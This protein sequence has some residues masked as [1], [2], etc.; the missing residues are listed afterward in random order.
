[1]AGE[2]AS[3]C[4]RLASV[5]LV[6]AMAAAPIALPVGTALHDRTEQ[7]GCMDRPVDP[8]P[9]YEEA[10]MLPHEL[11]PPPD[12]PPSVPPIPDP[13]EQISCPPSAPNN[14]CEIVNL[15]VAVAMWF[16]Q[17]FD[18]NAEQHI[19][20]EGDCA[21]LKQAVEELVGDLVGQVP[22]DAGPTSTSVGA[23]LHK[24]SEFHLTGPELVTFN[25]YDATAGG[26]HTAGPDLG[27]GLDDN[28]L[29]V[30]MLVLHGVPPDVGGFDAHPS[31]PRISPIDVC[32]APP[33]S[34]CS[35]SLRTFHGTNGVPTA[36][37][38]ALGFTIS[39]SDDIPSLDAARDCRTSF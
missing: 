33:G 12:L 8:C 23:S 19:L 13:C 2:N 29:G 11:P 37:A 5:A 36:C 18:P 31:S 32:E 7:I 27:K 3:I 26:T 15:S 21:A 30:L 24:T 35:T 22:V 1:M 16:V 6:I 34:S 25:G 9:I 14:E 17:Q 10:R 38:T 28:A 20:E 39:E 4:S